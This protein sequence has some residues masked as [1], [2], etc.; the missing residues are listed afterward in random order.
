M[1]LYLLYHKTNTKVLL[2]HKS[3]TKVLCIV[4]FVH[5]DSHNHH[6]GDLNPWPPLVGQMLSPLWHPL[7]TFCFRKI[8]GHHMSIGHNFLKIILFPLHDSRHS[9]PVASVIGLDHLT[10][11]AAHWRQ[12]TS[13]KR[14]YST[15]S[16][17]WAKKGNFNTI[18]RL[19]NGFIF[20]DKL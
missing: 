1:Q 11:Q 10:N 17:S 8:I 9:Y 4:Y 18:L 3:N 13:S 14:I 16:T 12:I 5:K 15:S 7:L 20:T 6:T 19:A 2:H